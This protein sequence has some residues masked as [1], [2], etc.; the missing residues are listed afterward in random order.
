MLNVQRLRSTHAAREELE[1]LP[2]RLRNKNNSC[3]LD[4]I[5]Y[6]LHALW[7]HKC[8]NTY[9][10]ASQTYSQMMTLV[11]QLSRARSSAHVDTLRDAIQQNLSH[12]P[13]GP[14][15][16]AAHEVPQQLKFLFGKFRR[17]PEIDFQ[18][19]LILRRQSL[20]ADCGNVQVFQTTATHL[21]GPLPPALHN[22]TH[23][24]QAARN[25]VR[26]A[27]NCSVCGSENVT[28]FNAEVTLR[29][30]MFVL[31]AN[32]H[33]E[34]LETTYPEAARVHLTDVQLLAFSV[35]VRAHY[36]AF[37]RLPGLPVRWCLFDDLHDTVVFG[38]LQEA[39][40]YLAVRYPNTQQR[41]EHDP[42]VDTLVYI[43]V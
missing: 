30:A 39:R 41:L 1:S 28:E 40:N 7:S 3:W 14:A 5:A 19:L 15:F 36:V 8:F 10:Q 4:T 38:S 22:Y 23:L 35:V 2:H 12:A 43:P 13:A 18:F 16:G 27:S 25:V 21:C 20:C 17:N 42:I 32:A 24:Q 9:T 11:T 37:A 6:L 33:L 26:N 29:K 34:S 31:D